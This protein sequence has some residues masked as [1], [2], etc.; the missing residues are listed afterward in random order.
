MLDIADA[1]LL[2]TRLRLEPIAVAHARA[3]FDV[4]RDPA[5]YCWIPQEPPASV[6]DVE[7]RF[8][9]IS[10]RTA[11]GR[12]AQWLNWT[13]WR[14]AEAI[15]IV[16]ATVSADAT[17]DIAYLFSPRI[18]G[19]GFA[20]EAVAAA[21]DAMAAAGATRFDAT[22]DARNAPSRALVQRLGFSCIAHNPRAAQ[23]KG[24]WSDEEVW[25]RAL[26]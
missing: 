10:Q 5:I 3:M 2:T 1:P 13:V 6:A 4:L 25:R 24:E 20:S 12:D 18:W 14:D 11:P 23:F 22:L 17:A 9:R 26:G 7:A 21:L 16:E 19:Q 8:A 15:G